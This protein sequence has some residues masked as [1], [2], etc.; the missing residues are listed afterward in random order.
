MNEESEKEI[1]E[2][3]KQKK[4]AK[5]KAQLEKAKIR[6]TQEALQVAQQKEVGFHCQ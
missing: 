3:K 5:K 6:K 1:E 2:A 4:K